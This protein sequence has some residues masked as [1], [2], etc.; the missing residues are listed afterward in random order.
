METPFI[1]VV[2]VFP[3][4]VNCCFRGEFKVQIKVMQNFCKIDIIYIA[5]TTVI[6]VI[7]AVIIIIIIIIIILPN[8]VFVTMFSH[9]TAPDTAVKKASLEFG[10]AHVFA[11][12]SKKPCNDISNGKRHIRITPCKTKHDLPHYIFFD[13]S[14]TFQVLLAEKKLSCEKGMCVHMLRD[15]CYPAPDNLKNATV[16]LIMVILH[17][18]L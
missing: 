16:L 11:G 8:A 18:H 3:L 10:E 17:W 12:K 15:A 6:F 1:S 5:V 4:C 14:R 2:I 13:D 7:I 9:N